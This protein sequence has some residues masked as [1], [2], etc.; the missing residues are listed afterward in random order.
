MLEEE[1]F[2]LIVQING[3]FRGR[4]FAAKG[5]SEEEARAKA[6]S[7]ESVKNHITGK[8]KKVIFVPDKLIN[9]VL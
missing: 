1:N 5:I 6:V 7:I 9:F 3:K 2:E 8:P 4:V